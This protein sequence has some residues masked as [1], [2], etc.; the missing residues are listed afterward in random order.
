MTLMAYAFILAPCL[1]A[2]VACIGFYVFTR[3]RRVGKH[4]ERLGWRLRLVV[5]GRWVYEEKKDNAWVGIPFE[6]IP[7]F[8]EPPYVIVAPS[9]DTWRT[10]PSWA[11]DRRNEIIGRVRSELESRNYVVEVQDRASSAYSR[12]VLRGRPDLRRA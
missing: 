4:D 11:T 6:E 5:S 7:D 2:A 3:N 12:A 1:G 10:F 9:E 8:R